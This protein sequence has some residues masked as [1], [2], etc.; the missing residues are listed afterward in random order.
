VT[1]EDRILRTRPQRSSQKMKRLLLN[2][3]VS[4]LK[5]KH[6]EKER[7]RGEK[8]ANRRRDCYSAPCSPLVRPF[9]GGWGLERTRVHGREIVVLIYFRTFSVM[10]TRP[11]EREGVTLSLIVIP[12]HCL[13]S[14]W[15]SRSSMAV[16][17]TSKRWVTAQGAYR[18]TCL[19][20]V[21]AMLPLYCCGTGTQAR[22]A[23]GP[24]H[25]G[26]D[27]PRE[28]VECSTPR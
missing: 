19:L 5:V 11:C 1:I 18:R 23:P 10:C 25:Q 4:Q 7:L 24:R 13:C 3:C 21:Q 12:T 27:K 28:T 8:E 9:V 2:W 14:S 16:S 6:R 17:P 26:V 20:Q 22:Y 15:P